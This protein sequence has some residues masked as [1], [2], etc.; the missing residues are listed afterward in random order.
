[1]HLSRS[2]AD[3]PRWLFL[4]LLFFAPLAYGCTN[5][6]TVIAFN[7]LAGGL[8]AQWLAVCL[9]RRRCPGVSW[10]PLTIVALLLLQGW[11]FAWNA[12]TVNVYRTWLT[13]TRIWD[14]PPLPDW[15]GAMDRHLAHAAMLNITALAGLFL[16]ACD[17]MRRPLWRKRVWATMAF[18]AVAVAATGIALK[19]GPEHWRESV[20][21]A[22]VAK[23]PTTFSLYRYHGN[24]ATL[25]AIGWAL[26]L[27]FIVPAVSDRAR[28]LRFSG[29]LAAA[30]G[31]FAGLAISTSRAGWVLAGMVALV[32][33]GRFTFA[34]WITRRET[35]DWRVMGIQGAVL[36]AVVGTVVAVGM[37][38]DNRLKLTRLQTTLQD[39]Q[40]R[41]PAAVYRH[42]A[43]ETGWLG[44]GANCFQV[45]LPTYMEVHGMATE[46]YGYW[47][48]AHN[49]YYEYHT[50]WGKWGSALWAVLIGGG[51][52]IALRD[53]FRSPPIWA[54]TQWALSFAGCV[55]MGVVLLH[56]GWDFPLEIPSIQVFFYTLMADGWARLQ[57]IGEEDLA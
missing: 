28:P 46:K 45:V 42:M 15:P 21:G 20:W 22:S 14:F 19:M 30:L 18:S 56:A 9:W 13:Y 12:H 17:L 40:A 44:Y 6:A 43:S 23:I 34:W 55:A 54:S 25:L 2:I 53:H 27:G 11:W 38:T 37:Q 16:F 50:S 32:M 39:L 31:I 24:A 51:W 57:P 10:W 5:K 47:E 52:F 8:L 1:M 3:L 48:H 29:W 35:M 36:I 26:T 33:A 7:G 41:F 49:D 4:A